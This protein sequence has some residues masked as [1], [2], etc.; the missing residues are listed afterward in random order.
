MWKVVV[1]GA[2]KLNL[3]KNEEEEETVI[4]LTRWKG[5]N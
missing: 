3:E 5:E 4:V 1:G 2:E